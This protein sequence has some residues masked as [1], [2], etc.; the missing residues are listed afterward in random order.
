LEV[1][2]VY[3]KGNEAQIEVRGERHTLGNMVAKELQSMDEVDLAY[4]EIPHPLQDRM[5]IYIRTRGD[6]SPLEAL[7]KALDSLE[8]RLDELDKALKKALGAGESET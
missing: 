4:Y 5:L 1:K 6:V 2:L 8:D 3:S 7:R